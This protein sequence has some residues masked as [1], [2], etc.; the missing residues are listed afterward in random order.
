MMTR[1]RRLSAAFGAT[2]IGGAILAASPALATE[3]IE[4]FESSVSTTQAGGHPDIHTSFTLADPGAPE[5]ARN[6]IFNAP[7]GVFGNPQRDHRVR[8]V[9]LRPPAV[10]LRLPGRA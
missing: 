8:P 1:A 2:L 3:T 9:E 7:A 10:P 6:V 4:S 5:A